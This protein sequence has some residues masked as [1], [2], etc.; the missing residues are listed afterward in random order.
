M[1]A[2]FKFELDNIEL[3]KVN[4]F[5]NSVD[6]CSIE[7]SVGWTPLLYKSKICYFYLIE[8]SEIKSFCQIHEK[9]KFAQIIFGPVCS[10]KE[11]MITSINEI[12]NY[13]KK[14]G[15][16]SLGIQMYYKSG[17]DSEYI[18]YILNSQHS[19]HYLFNNENTK[20]S[21]EVNLEDSDEEIFK[22]IRENHRRNIKKAIK[23]E[24]SVDVLKSN[25]EL[26]AFIDVYT[27]MCKV[28]G[29]QGSGISSKNIKEIYN[30]LINN[31]K[32][33]ILIAKDKD[34]IILGGVIIAYQGIS[35]RYLLGASDPDRRDLPILHFVLYEAIKKAKTDNFRYFDFWGYSH[36]VKKG[37][38]IF[39][40]NHFKKGFGGYYT[41]FTKK[42]NIDL[43]P[44][45]TTIYR[46]IFLVRKILNR[47][48]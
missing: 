7:Q 46:F 2:V 3:D 25:S 38:Q 43:V 27:K 36:F 6:Y 45:G 42:M 12:I 4:R 37:D 29:I 44:C 8:D 20:S 13:Y 33:Q 48:L 31:N 39:D 30:Y 35:V 32:G 1:G 9:L 18:E 40:I 34:N 23:S 41:F 14:R 15:F 17:F 24:I 26:L 10:D 5:C 19:I 21:I 28:R 11:L 47:L 22:K 16:Y